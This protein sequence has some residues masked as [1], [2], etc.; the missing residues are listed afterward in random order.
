[1]LVL[2]LLASHRIAPVG[3]TYAKQSRSSEGMVPRCA[4]SGA[5]STGE[6]VRT[7]LPLGPSCDRVLPYV[8]DGLPY[9][10]TVSCSLEG[11][12]TNT[13]T[14]WADDPLTHKAAVGATFCAW[15]K[16]VSP[17]WA[18]IT[19]IRARIGQRSHYIYM[20][21]PVK[22]QATSVFS[23]LRARNSKIAGL[24]QCATLIRCQ[25][26]WLS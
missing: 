22:V 13:A 3:S 25:A 20:P 15:A 4:S 18:L 11:L 1:M 7:V 14:Q 23:M 24:S 16:P 2:A 5:V 21:E 26:L 19:S 12:P 10:Q 6:Y 9:R 17:V 8:D